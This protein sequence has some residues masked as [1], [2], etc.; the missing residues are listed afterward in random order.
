MDML[1]AEC[2]AEVNKRGID[3]D[4]LL[5]AVKKVLHVAEMTEAAPDAVASHVLVQ[6][7]HLARREPALEENKIKSHSH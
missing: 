5:T 6:D 2:I 1:R 4:V 7:V 3:H